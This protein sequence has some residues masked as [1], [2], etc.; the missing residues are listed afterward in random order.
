MLTVSVAGDTGDEIAVL[1]LFALHRLPLGGIDK[2]VVVRV[3]LGEAFGRT[4]E[5]EWRKVAVAVRV[6]ART[7]S[8][9]VWPAE[10]G[11][12]ESVAR[13]RVPSSHARCAPRFD[14]ECPPG[15]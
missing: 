10:D 11:V 14:R 6:H 12:A 9:C 15:G 1:L 7:S 8:A 2:T 13:P 4:Q 3:E 5:F